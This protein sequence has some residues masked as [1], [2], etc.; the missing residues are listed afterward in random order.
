MIRNEIELQQTVESIALMQQG[1]L[2]LVKNQLPR[3]RQLFAVMAEA[4][5][6]YIRQFCDEIEQYRASLA[7]TFPAEQPQPT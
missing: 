4:P 1:L 2:D 3:N 5:L 7:P 6:D